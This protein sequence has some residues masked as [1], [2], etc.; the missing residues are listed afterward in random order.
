MN[1]NIGAEDDEALDILWSMVMEEGNEAAMRNLDSDSAQTMLKSHAAF[2]A[3]LDLNDISTNKDEM[4]TDVHVV[5]DKNQVREDPLPDLIDFTP[6]SALVSGDFWK[7]VKVVISCAYPLPI[8]VGN[9]E[10]YLV[11]ARVKRRNN[12]SA[13]LAVKK[14]LL[15]PVTP[16]NPYTYRCN[17]PLI[18]IPPGPRFFTIIESILPESKLESAVSDLLRYAWAQ[19]FQNVSETDGK[20]LF[21]PSV[22]NTDSSVRILSQISNCFFEIIDPYRMD[23]SDSGESE[24]KSDTSVDKQSAER[25][26]SDASQSH[27][28][29]V[30]GPAP[31]PAMAFV[32]AALT[33]YPNPGL[34]NA[35]PYRQLVPTSETQLSNSR[36][37]ASVDNH[38]V[39]QN[40]DL[41]GAASDW[42]NA[43]S[44]D[45]DGESKLQSLDRRCKVRLVERLTNV[46]GE[47]DNESTVQHDAKVKAANPDMGNFLLAGKSRKVHN[48]PS[49]H[50]RGASVTRINEKQSE[51]NIGFPL[52]VRENSSPD[53][54]IESINLSNIGEDEMDSLLDGLL[55]RIVENL[56]EMTSSS[57]DLKV[58]LN[59]PDQS[60]FTLLH[61]VSFGFTYNFKSLHGFLHYY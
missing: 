1:I 34:T 5:E 38:E 21:F 40:A 43:P 57:Q 33:D 47:T 35:V 44:G 48:N 6:E 14:I 7:H 37:R 27:Q 16:L 24:S 30:F 9:W 18:G 8:K 49:M 42:A 59:R 53:S 25:Q 56:M 41:A 58:E 39:D 4:D 28:R 2:S 46:I 51:A 20:P 11:A 32:A 60:G 52:K 61:Y 10:R 29:K 23:G 55:V 17:I 15:I 26:S 13:E 54:L 31:N 50:S 45:K 19:S 36:K 3:M 22:N 12:L